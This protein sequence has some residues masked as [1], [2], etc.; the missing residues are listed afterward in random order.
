[1]MPTPNFTKVK[2]IKTN[3]DGSADIS[4][5]SVTKKLSSVKQEIQQ[6]IK[7][8]RQNLAA[9]IISCLQHITYHET[10]ELTIH[11]TTDAAGDPS[12]ITKTWLVHKEYY[13]K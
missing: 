2:T 10:S 11:I 5:H 1:M 8:D 12:I 13:G 4:T 9:D 6:S 7:T 3:D